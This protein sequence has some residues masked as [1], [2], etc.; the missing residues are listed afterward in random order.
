MIDSNNLYHTAYIYIYIYICKL[1]NNTIYLARRLWY[2]HSDRAK[3]LLG[4]H[5]AVY[6]NLVLKCVIMYH[7][8]N[9]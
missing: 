1:Y 5:F 4:S 7:S 6:I 3:G 2:N 9:M 8:S